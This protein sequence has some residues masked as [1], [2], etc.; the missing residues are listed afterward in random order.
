MRGLGFFPDVWANYRL[1]E[2]PAL[3]FL[4]RPANLATSTANRTPKP[5]AK[6]H[7]HP[8]PF[9]CHNAINSP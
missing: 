6:Q 1:I 3:K 4:L 5:A 9:R 8:N 2:T 7:H